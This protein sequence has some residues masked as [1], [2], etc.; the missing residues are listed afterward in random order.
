[1]VVIGWGLSSQVGGAIM[2][3]LLG[4]EIRVNQIDVGHFAEMDL[5]WEQE[6]WRMS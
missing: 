3:D 5:M 2:V 4:M 6:E 1:M